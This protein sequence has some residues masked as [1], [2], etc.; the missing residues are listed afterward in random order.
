MSV[1][2]NMA[3]EARAAHAHYFGDY[4]QLTEPPATVPE[5]VAAVVGKS[6]VE[7]R[8]DEHGR[9]IRVS[10][11]NIRFT[12]LATVRHDAT[13]RIDDVDWTIDRIIKRDASGLYAMLERRDTYQ[14]ARPNYR[15]KP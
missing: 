6:S 5:T 9:Q 12:T 7:T 2:G 14:V 15:G 1:F 11:R 13:V 8:T 10:V 4:V 3:G